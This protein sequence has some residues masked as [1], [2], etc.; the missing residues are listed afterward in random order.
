MLFTFRLPF[1]LKIFPADPDEVRISQN[2]EFKKRAPSRVWIGE[3]LGLPI[4]DYKGKIY[5][6]RVWDIF[7]FSN[8]FMSYLTVHPQ[9]RSL[10]PVIRLLRWFKASIRGTL[11]NIFNIK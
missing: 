3:L 5:L 8:Y 10:L 2:L 7:S 11:K 9:L 6:K 1:F 4:P